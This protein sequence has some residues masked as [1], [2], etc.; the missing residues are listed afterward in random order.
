MR[1]ETFRL[2]VNLN[3]NENLKIFLESFP[4]F[5]IKYTAF[6]RRKEVKKE[7]GRRNNIYEIYSE[8]F[9]LLKFIYF[10]CSLFIFSL[11]LDKFILF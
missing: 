1:R 10:Y 7:Q 9:Q 5:D 11:L 6:Q 2:Q 8:I 4:E 3:L